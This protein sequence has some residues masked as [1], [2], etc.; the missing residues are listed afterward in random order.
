MCHGHSDHVDFQVSEISE[1][2]AQLAE[3]AAS[4]CVAL[5]FIPR[6]V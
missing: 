5:V 1:H 2:V 3:Q 6:T 4:M